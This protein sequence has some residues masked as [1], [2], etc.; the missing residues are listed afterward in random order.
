MIGIA[1]IS[2]APAAS[3]PAPVAAVPVLAS[4]ASPTAV[5]IAPVGQTAAAVAG[6]AAST[7]GGTSLM[8]HMSNFLQGNY[9]PQ[10][11]LLD[12]IAPNARASM[13]GWLKMAQNI[14]S[15]SKFSVSGKKGWFG[16]NGDELMSNMGGGGNQA[17]LMAALSGSAES[18]GPTMKNQSSVTPMAPA[19]PNLRAVRTMRYND[20]GAEPLGLGLKPGFGR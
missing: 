19:S 6:G 7:G 11:M 2:L 13:P 20:W 9:N 17:A 12:A 8:G 15:Q 16:I 3:A 10:N 4:E 1:P 5:S 18:A 14:G